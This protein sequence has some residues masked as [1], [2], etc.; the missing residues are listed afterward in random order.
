MWLQWSAIGSSIPSAILLIST[1]RALFYAGIGTLLLCGMVYCLITLAVHARFR[2]PIEKTDSCPSCGSRDFR[3]SYEVAFDRVRKK[4][5]I[6]PF[7]CRRC[8]KRFFRRSLRGG[9]YG[10]PSAVDN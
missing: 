2:R 5:G 10:I 8:L 9:A 3:S 1:K 7:R 4:F 6:Y